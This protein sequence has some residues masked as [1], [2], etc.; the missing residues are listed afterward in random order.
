MKSAGAEVAKFTLCICSGTYT[1]GNKNGHLQTQKHTKYIEIQQKITAAKKSTSPTITNWLTSDKKTQKHQWFEEIIPIAA[2]SEKQQ[3]HQVYSWT[4]YECF[5]LLS[6]KNSEAQLFIPEFQ[7]GVVWK[8]PEQQALIA[9]LHEKNPCGILTVYSTQCSNKMSYFIIDGQQRLV[10]LLKYYNNPCLYIPDLVDRITHK[11]APSSF[12]KIVSE[13]TTSTYSLTTKTYNCPFVGNYSEIDE[14]TKS[15]FTFAKSF[16]PEEGDPFYGCGSEENFRNICEKTCAALRKCIHLIDNVRIPYTN[17]SGPEENIS[18]VYDALNKKHTPLSSFDR[19]AAQWIQYGKFRITI[20]EIC[21]SLYEKYMTDSEMRGISYSGESVEKDKLSFRDK[22]HNL[23]QFCKGFGAYIYKHKIFSDFMP[24]G[25]DSI[26][27]AFSILRG[28]YNTTNADLPKLVLGTK[29]IEDADSSPKFLFN[30][31]AQRKL[32]DATNE[33]LVIIK[34]TIEPFNAGKRNVIGSVQQIASFV[35]KYYK[36][37]GNLQLVQKF[38]LAMKYH[39]IYDALDEVWKSNAATLFRARCDTPHYEN[40]VTQEKWLSLT[41]KIYVNEMKH[42]IKKR[43]APSNVAKLLLEMT[44][45]HVLTTYENHTIE[46]QF[47]HI[48]PFHTLEQLKKRH[49]GEIIPANHVAN[50]CLLDS[51]TNRRKG[52]MTLREFIISESRQIGKQ[53]KQTELENLVLLHPI[54]DLYFV[55]TS[56]FSPDRFKAYL[57]YRYNNL[58]QKFFSLYGILL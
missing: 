10:T 42:D 36:I 25:G 9:T 23:H 56:E 27:V 15:L 31:D 12:K 5:Q 54:E 52:S 26:I 49:E 57:K 47:D 33:C 37:H 40:R 48:I 29:N 50:L 4:V 11:K 8:L 22:K 14:G 1:K 58:M 21:D 7:R 46:R 34:N 17:Y 32:F 45:C 39:I 38:T 20:P 30:H 3:H 2:E 24:T 51:I 41:E 35:A 6:N 16:N 19:F 18:H 44:E 43:C 13:W 53:T 55:E 28:I